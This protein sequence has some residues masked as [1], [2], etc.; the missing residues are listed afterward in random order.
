ME[1]C[2]PPTAWA[3]VSP[4]GRAGRKGSDLCVHLLD[5][6][7]PPP[8]ACLSCQPHQEI[9]NQETLGLSRRGRGL[10]QSLVPGPQESSRWEEALYP[11]G[12]DRLKANKV[13]LGSN[14]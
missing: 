12:I 2:T 3:A 7:P 4:A 1:G 5:T 6:T 9:A 14:P 10:G 13:K 8:H 11:K